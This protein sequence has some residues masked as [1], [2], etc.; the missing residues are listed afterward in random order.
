MIQIV[1][2]DDKRLMDAAAVLPGKI[3]V[4]VI[5]RS[6]YNGTKALVCRMD[7]ADGGQ[8]VGVYVCLVWTLVVTIPC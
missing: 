3:R 5:M 4:D 8:G 2:S 1:G 7:K 6:A